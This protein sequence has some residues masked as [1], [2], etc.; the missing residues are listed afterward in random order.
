MQVKKIKAVEIFL[1]IYLIYT[2]FYQLVD[3]FGGAVLSYG[4]LVFPVVMCLVLYLLKN[5]GLVSVG[6]LRYFTGWWIIAIIV[7]VHNASFKHGI[8]FD[9]IRL[10]IVIVLTFVL[11]QCKDWENSAIKIMIVLGM[12]HALS[13]I[14]FFISNDIFSQFILPLFEYP[15]VGSNNGLEG[16]HSGLSDHYSLNGTYCGVTTIILGAQIIANKAMK[17]KVKITTISLFFL[18]FIALLLTSKRAHLLFSVIALVVVYYVI[19]PEKRSNKMFKIA[20]LGVAALLV[21]AIL[22]ETGSPLAATFNRFLESDK[23]DIS[24]GRFIMWLL[25]IQEFLNHPII[26][27]GW[28]G[29]RYSYAENLFVAGNYAGGEYLEGFK[30]LDTHNV[31]LQVLCETGIIGFAFFLIAILVPLISA[32]RLAKEFLRERNICIVRQ[33]AF[34]IGI[35]VFMLVYCLTGCCI[36]DITFLIYMMSVAVVG[37]IA[38]KRNK[39][40]NLVKMKKEKNY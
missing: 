1:F 30:L 28:Q 37:S 7:L 21:I 24:N 11:S 20:L 19:N 33:L 40:I 38:L 22:I 6:G 14:V 39:G 31:Y 29:Y 2:Y 16:F 10:I 36:N 27:L 26:G 34:S 9:S 5:K 32:F 23:G 17:R 3:I 25:A 18:S 4:S 35:Q 13:T 12:I 8:Y 15:P